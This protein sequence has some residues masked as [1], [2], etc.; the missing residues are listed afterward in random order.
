M[1]EKTSI[2]IMFINILQ[3]GQLWNNLN[4]IV[5]NRRIKNSIIYAKGL[6]EMRNE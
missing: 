5:C 3:T 2:V 6:S 4:F 1:E